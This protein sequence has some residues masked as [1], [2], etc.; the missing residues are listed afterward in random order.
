MEK[1]NGLET[2]TDSDIVLLIQSSTPKMSYNTA[3]ICAK[4]ILEMFE[5]KVL[6]RDPLLEYIEKALKG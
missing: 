6:V 4:D 3:E 2:F 5:G 1:I